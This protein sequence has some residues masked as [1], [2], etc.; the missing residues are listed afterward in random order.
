MGEVL[1]IG[2]YDR[3]RMP[4]HE[5]YSESRTAELL[6]RGLEST[7]FSFANQFQYLSEQFSTRTLDVFEG[8]CGNG[9]TLRGLREMGTRLGLEIRTT[10]VTMARRNIRE[11]VANGVD[12]LV[13]GR[14][15]RYF[16]LNDTRKRFHFIVDSDGALQYDHIRRNNRLLT[17]ARV[18]PVYSDLLEPG[19]RAFLTIGGHYMVLSKQD[20]RT[21]ELIYGENAPEI[22]DRLQANGLE[23]LSYYRGIVLV[24]KPGSV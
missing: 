16:A 10:G 6:K 17:G 18:I 22:M 21:R 8:G 7:D 3:Y 14:V 12:T 15:E 24:Q 1:R 2:P 23:I 5:G 11:A 20:K 19:G 4:S 13:V 9:V